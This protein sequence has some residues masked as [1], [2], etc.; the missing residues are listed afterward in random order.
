[1]P[2]GVNNPG[3][4]QDQV[5][6]PNMPKVVWHLVYEKGGALP[7][8]FSVVNVFDAEFFEFLFG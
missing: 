4:G 5:N 3:V 6:Q 2:A 7:M 8:N 1:M